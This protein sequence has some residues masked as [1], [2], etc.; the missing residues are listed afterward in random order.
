MSTPTEAPGEE[1]PQ[2]IQLNIDDVLF[3]LQDQISVLSSQLAMAK[4]QIRGLN[5]EIVELRKRP[6]RATRRAQPK[7]E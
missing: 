6:A 1:S 4:A 3:E 7:S 5:R 2:G